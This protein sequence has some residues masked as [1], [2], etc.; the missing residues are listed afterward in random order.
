M[1][2]FQCKFR[3]KTTR[4]QD[5]DYASPGAYFITLCTRGREHFFGDVV[6][7]EMKR[8]VIGEVAH[9]HWVE[10][11]IHFPH[12]KPD[13]FVVMPNYVHGILVIQYF[14][15]TRHVASLPT[16][17]QFG[18]LRPGS[19]SKIVQAYKASVTRWCNKNKQSA[20]AWQPRFYESILRDETNL[21]RV[22]E[23]IAQNPIQ[24]ALDQE[25]ATGLWM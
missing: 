4:L 6:E 9:N 24:W 15:E 21:K 5:W 11:P 14:V 17:N 7:G 10:I 3:I 8:S 23:Y 12:I 2:K 20:F 18:P 13:E 1:E 19:L 25:N 22:R 16:S